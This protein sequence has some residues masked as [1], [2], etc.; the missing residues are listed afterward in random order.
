VTGN[1]RDPMHAAAAQRI[2]PEE[3]REA[4]EPTLWLLERANEGIKLTQT[5]ALNRTLVREFAERWPGWWE[6][7]LFGPPHRET[8]VNRLWELHQLLRAVRL[9]RRRGP[10][11]F[12]T[13]R[14]REL[15]EYP[16]ALLQILTDELLSGDSFEAACA[17]LAAEVILAGAKADFGES[18]A[19]QI[20]PAIIAQGW[21]ADGEQ[22]DVRDISW[23]IAGFLRPAEAIGLFQRKEA[24]QRLGE[25]LRLREVGRTTL[26]AALHPR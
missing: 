5:G 11:I 16:A 20:R 24:P 26:I 17:E 6:A 2:D 18:L 21:E 19:E 1:G 10:K 12:A 14:G 8:D 3:A 23:A 7:D 13:K 25:P 15:Q 22:P 9:L 4:L